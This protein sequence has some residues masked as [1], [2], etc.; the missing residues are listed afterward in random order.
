M[1]P[2]KTGRISQQEKLE[3]KH[4]SNFYS[5]WQRLSKYSVMKRW[6]RNGRCDE[7]SQC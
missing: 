3:L 7:C 4:E 6:R 2:N 1:K 5:D